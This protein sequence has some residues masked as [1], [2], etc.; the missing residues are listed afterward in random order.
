MGLQTLVTMKMLPILVVLVAATRYKAFVEYANVV[1]T[2][3]ADQT[4][5]YEGENNFLSILTPLER[6]GHMGLNVSGHE[7]GSSSDTPMMMQSSGLKVAASRDFS[8]KIAGIK[9]QGNCGSCW[10]FAATAALEGEMYFVNSKKGVSLSE[11]EY[12]ECSTSRDGCQGGWMADC[13]TYTRSK[14]R[15]APT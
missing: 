14:D 13:Y 6:E 15:I 12:M 4:I 10:T 8:K 5:P 2:V 9:N 3:N 11:Q 1:N 7:A